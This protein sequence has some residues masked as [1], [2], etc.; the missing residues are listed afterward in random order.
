MA[1]ANTTAL[2]A[3]AAQNIN[4]P[5]LKQDLNKLFGDNIPRA[6]RKRGADALSTVHALDSIKSFADNA[7]W[8]QT[9][10]NTADK[11]IADAWPDIWRWI[12]Y[13]KVNI[14][15]DSHFLPAHAVLFSQLGHLMA[16][17]CSSPTI[18]AKVIQTSGALR[19][20]TKE[21]LDEW[22]ECSTS[23]P[24]DPTWTRALGELVYFEPTADYHLDMAMGRQR[25]AEMFKG[26]S[27]PDSKNGLVKAMLSQLRIHCSTRSNLS[28]PAIHLYNDFLEK[29]LRTPLGIINDLLEAGLISLII[30]FIDRLQSNVMIS[31]SGKN[32]MI[33]ST[34]LTLFISV[35]LISNGSLWTVAFLDGGGLQ[36]YLRSGKFLDCTTDNFE[37]QGLLS[38]LG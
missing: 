12:V 3:L 36:T 20:V 33:P 16:N 25:A 1:Q 37:Y 5:I 9:A 31:T 18:K 7:V 6:S 28:E 8:I 11:L 35:I 2:Q 29:I 4:F 34:V 13:F 38:Q 23:P 21:W 30:Q 27:T 17:F 22:K 14:T 26:T 19:F 32:A 24:T 15:A 10:S